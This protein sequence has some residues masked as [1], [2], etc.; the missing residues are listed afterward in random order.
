MSP[1]LTRIRSYSKQNRAVDRR[2]E[3]SPESSSII[4]PCIRNVIGIR[5]YE[6]SCVWYIEEIS[7]RKEQINQWFGNLVR[8]GNLAI[9]V[10]RRVY[11]MCWETNVRLHLRLIWLAASYIQITANATILPSHPSLHELSRSM[12]RRKRTIRGRVCLFGS[13]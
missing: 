1:F 10:S 7:A 5:T 9:Q 12:Y 4:I 2:Y 11:R 3:S 13:S 8:I 6:N